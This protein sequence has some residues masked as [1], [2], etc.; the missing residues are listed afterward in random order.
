MTG[1]EKKIE[2]IGYDYTNPEECLKRIKCCIS[3]P[4]ELQYMT[5][6]TE[7][8]CLIACEREGDALQYVHN[9]TE[10]IC[11]TAIH[12]DPYALQYVKEQTEKICLAAIEQDQTVLEF[13]DDKF[14]YLFD[15][16]K[17]DF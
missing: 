9:Q 11:L 17:W 13:V 1:K 10:K 4:Y 3:S 2:F 12:D 6:Q 8:I 15:N 5:N 7:E 16:W 14:L